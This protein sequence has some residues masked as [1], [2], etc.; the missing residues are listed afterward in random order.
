ME[1]T[2]ASPIAASAAAMAITKIAK[3]VPFN[4]RLSNR[5]EKVTRFILT[6]FSKSSRHISALTMFRLVINPKMPIENKKTL[7]K[8]TCSNILR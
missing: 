3:I 7:K 5:S 1:E 8:S 6:E 2:I 4:C